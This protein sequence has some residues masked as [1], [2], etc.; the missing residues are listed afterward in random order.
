MA[1]PSGAV[2]PIQP[3]GRAD[4]SGHPWRNRR[5]IAQQR[6]MADTRLAQRQG[7]SI[8]RWVV[9]NAANEL[10]PSTSRRGGHGMRPAGRSKSS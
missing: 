8:A 2:A 4:W 10:D 5:R 3:R 7:T 1:R 9:A 6:S